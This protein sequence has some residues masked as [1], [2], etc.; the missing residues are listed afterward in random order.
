MRTVPRE[1]FVP[2]D[3]RAEAFEDHPLTIGH[4]Q[5]ISQPYMVA[6]MAEAARLGPADRVLEVGTGSGYG[7]A[8]LRELAASVTTVE[9]HEHL[10]E[11]AS[12]RLRDLGYGDIEVI[13]GDGSLGW[14]EQAPYDAIVVTAASPKPPE[15][16]L[17]QLTDTGRLIV[18]VGDNRG[19]QNLV[20][21]TRSGDRFRRE[22]LVGVRF[23]PL[24]G[25]H[26]FER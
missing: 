15:P 19:A 25:E 6:M 22:T 26:G 18:P 23:V 11:T 2:V 12:T 1:Q 17:E 3:S 4:G 9:R 5:T 24:I 16:L 14:A 13:V 21:I 20:R 8:V 10:A 7:A